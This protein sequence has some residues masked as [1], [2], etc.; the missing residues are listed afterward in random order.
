MKHLLYFLVFLITIVSCKEEIKSKLDFDKLGVSEENR[1]ENPEELIE[2][3]KYPDSVLIDP[4]DIRFSFEFDTNFIN[5]DSTVSKGFIRVVGKLENLSTNPAAILFSNFGHE[6]NLKI[7]NGIITECSKSDL[8]ICNKVLWRE[9]IAPQS[10]IFF[11]TCVKT[12]ITK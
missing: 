10:H 6:D 9:I 3:I 8:I 2:L 1:Y 7:K 12:I 4:N 5:Y 11:T